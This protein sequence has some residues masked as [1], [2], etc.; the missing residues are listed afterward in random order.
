MGFEGAGLPGGT[1]WAWRG[2]AL[3]VD[4]GTGLGRVWTWSG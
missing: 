1:A 2:L 3:E 4:Q